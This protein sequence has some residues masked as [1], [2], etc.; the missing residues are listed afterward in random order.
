MDRQ[1]K[2][3]AK[4][5]I[6]KVGSRKKLEQS[7]QIPPRNPMWNIW[8]VLFLILVVSLIEWPLGWLESPDTLDTLTGFFRYLA[9]GMGDAGLYLL[10]L[11]FLFRLIRRPF[12]DMGFV[13]PRLAQVVLGLFMGFILFVGISLLGNL[14]ADL[15]GEPEPQSF[16]LAV[17]GVEYGWQ[18]IFLLILGGIIAPLKEEAIFRG[19]V[20]PPL[21]N[22]H[23]KLKGILLTGLFFAVLHF[24]YIRFLPLFLGGVILAWMYE[25]TASLWPSIIAHGAWNMLMA[26]ALWLQP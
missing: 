11:Y 16:A 3:Q 24:D 22:T 18:F 21:R 15:L 17:E 26:M 23:G 20:Y 12:S 1:E 13:R 14:M 7:A 8:Q 5:T 10:L 2:K 4:T 6:K 9:M 25:R 19:L